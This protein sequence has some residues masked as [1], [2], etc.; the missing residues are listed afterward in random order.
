MALCRQTAV[1][2][3][4]MAAAHN[5]PAH[6]CRFKEHVELLIAFSERQH[7]TI[8]QH[9]RKERFERN[10]SKRRRHSREQ[11]PSQAEQS[12]AAVVRIPDVSLAFWR[13]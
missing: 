5:Q 12:L 9:L 3:A 7:K 6:T 2:G 13:R 11:P 10:A 8:L 1:D 4:Q